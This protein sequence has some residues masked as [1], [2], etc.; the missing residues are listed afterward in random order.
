MNAQT[1]PL[2]QTQ[3][4]TCVHVLLGI[5][6]MA[7]TAHLISYQES[8]TLNIYN[9][10]VIERNDNKNSIMCRYLFFYCKTEKYQILNA[11][12]LLKF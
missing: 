4:V 12:C 5:L 2:I 6:A 8:E 7:L 9:Y 1:T 11:F 3:L 10:V